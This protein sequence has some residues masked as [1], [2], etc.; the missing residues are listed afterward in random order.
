MAYAFSGRAPR[1]NRD[2]GVPMPTEILR[3]ARGKILTQTMGDASHP[4]SK[5]TSAAEAGRIQRL[6]GTTEVVPFPSAGDEQLSRLESIG[7]RP[8]AG[9]CETLL[10]PKTA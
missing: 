8:R 5:Q 9:W 3:C 10:L 7:F 6:I 1:I 4:P 2:T